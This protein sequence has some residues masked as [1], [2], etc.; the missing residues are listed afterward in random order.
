MVKQASAIENDEDALEQ[1]CGSAAMAER[2]KVLWA[3]IMEKKVLDVSD[4]GLND[5]DVTKLLKGLHMCAP[6][7]RAR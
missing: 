7:C 2:V 6:A 3:D 1:V 4:L 5:D